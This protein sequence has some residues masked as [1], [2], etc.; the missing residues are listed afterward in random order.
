MIEIFF[1]STSTISERV[2]TYTKGRRNK[3]NF[4]NNFKVVTGTKSALNEGTNVLFSSDLIYEQFVEFL[5]ITTFDD[6]KFT[7]DVVQEFL[8]LS[9]H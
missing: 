2:E 4:E 6:K 1:A 3:I 8:E 9:F 7:H 5:K